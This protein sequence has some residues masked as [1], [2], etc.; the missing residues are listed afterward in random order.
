LW[1]WG[2]NYS[3]GYGSTGT[4]GLNQ[5]D[6]GTAKLTPTQVANGGT[7]WKDVYVNGPATMAIRYDE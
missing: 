4:L 6:T 1:A 2:A 7:N 5:G 3:T